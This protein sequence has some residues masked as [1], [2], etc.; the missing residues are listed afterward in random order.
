MSLSRP[1]FTWSAVLGAGELFGEVWGHSGNLCGT[2]AIGK[3][4]SGDF[5]RGLRS[6]FIL[7]ARAVVA[8]P[9]IWLACEVYEAKAERCEIKLTRER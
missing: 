6:G 2:S 1:E 5:R 4:I 3:A 8:A 7:T 9:T